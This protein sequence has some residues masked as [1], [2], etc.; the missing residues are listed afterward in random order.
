[1]G[2]RA[3]SNQC[4]LLGVYNKF[5]LNFLIIESFRRV[6]DA[7]GKPVVANCNVAPPFGENNGAHLGIWILRPV[8]NVL[9]KLAESQ[10]PLFHRLRFDDE[11]HYFY[12][13]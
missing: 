4:I 7:H 8:G 3:G 6:L 10:I 12:S 2:A 13:G 5:K 1:M 9:G 11:V